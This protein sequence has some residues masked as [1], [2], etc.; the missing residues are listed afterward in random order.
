M[1]TKCRVIIACLAVCSLFGGVLLSTQSV[2]ARPALCEELQGMTYEGNNPEQQY[3]DQYYTLGCDSED[4]NTT[5]EAKVADVLTWVFMVIGILAVVSILYGAVRYVL[6]QGLPG[7]ISTAKNIILYSLIG[8][9]VSILAFAIV[10]F[11]VNAV[12]G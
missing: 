6:S 5:A 1:V 2:L 3:V 8:L 11:V 4:A 10:Q 7:E 12:D 9:V